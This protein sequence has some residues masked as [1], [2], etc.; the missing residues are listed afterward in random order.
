MKTYDLS[1][2]ETID[3]AISYVVSMARNSGEAVSMCS[4][5]WNGRKETHE[6]I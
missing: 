4:R 6:R 2:S 5:R 1:P 3:D